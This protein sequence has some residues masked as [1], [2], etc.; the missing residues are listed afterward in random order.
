MKY[1]SQGTFPP[2][3]VKGTNTFRG[4]K[5]NLPALWHRDTIE[6]LVPLPEKRKEN[7]DEET[8]IANH[9]TRNQLQEKLNLTN[10]QFITKVKNGDIPKP[11]VIGKTSK[12]DLWHNDAVKKIIK[13]VKYNKR[14]N[15]YLENYNLPWGKKREHY[16]NTSDLADLLG[17]SSTYGM[18]LRIKRDPEFP[19]PDVDKQH[20]NQSPLWLK[21]TI[22]SIGHRFINEYPN[23]LVNRK[24]SNDHIA[25]TGDI[26][27]HLQ[28]EHGWNKV[29]DDQLHEIAKLHSEDHMFSP[30]ED[31]INLNHPAFQDFRHVV[32]EDPEHDIK[33][34]S[35]SK[36]EPTD[37]EKQEANEKGVDLFY[38]NYA[39]KSGANHN[40]VLDAHEKGI[41]L[42]DY[43]FVRGYGATHDEALEVHKKSIDL[44]DYAEARRNGATHNETLDADNIGINVRRYALARAN[45]ATHN[46]ALDAHSKGIDLGNY[47][48]ARAINATHNEILD[49]HN[50]GINVSDYARARENNATHNEILD[51]DNKG[52]NVSDYARARANGATHDE[53]L[54]VHEKGIDLYDY[55]VARFNDDT[56]EQAVRKQIP[57]YNP[58]DDIFKK[59]SS[60]EKCGKTFIMSQR[61]YGI[62]EDH[63]IGHDCC[64]EPWTCGLPVGHEGKHGDIGHSNQHYTCPNGGKLGE[65]DPSSYWWDDAPNPY[66]EVFKQSSKDWYQQ[67]EDED[68]EEEEDDSTIEGRLGRCFQLAGRRAS[69]GVAFQR[70]SDPNPILVHGT[71]QGMGLSPLAHAWVEHSDGTVHEPTTDQTYPKEMFNAIFNPVEEKRY[72]RDELNKMM[73]KHQ[74]WGPWHD[75]KGRI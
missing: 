10:S 59:S 34:S 1:V 12:D 28:E 14:N 56:H 52:I 24:S 39:R 70:P 49:V 40:E 45:N 20:K 25:A 55:G 9:H 15:D 30:S 13:P 62:P 75:T 2:P 47:A 69:F 53:F 8:I 27:Q 32:R 19:S 72:D 31:D 48:Y 29:N 35:I 23:A 74:H 68:N 43:R 6:D 22:D 3:D 26:I 16:Y 67:D 4:D 60:Q 65:F 58:Y 37:S 21:K 61:F 17:Y 42:R 51:V 11:D 46:E 33:K 71:I 73:L 41:Y 54:D 64:Q 5:G 57:Y 7:Y 66:D 36:I 44:P 38:Y 63:Y 50:K 18:R